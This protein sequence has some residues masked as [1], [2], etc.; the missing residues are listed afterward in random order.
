MKA[1]CKDCGQVFEVDDDSDYA[2][3]PTLCEDCEATYMD[4]S[5]PDF[6]NYM[7]HSDADPGQ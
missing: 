4:E 2:S 3:R 7:D 6:F 5:D 1:K